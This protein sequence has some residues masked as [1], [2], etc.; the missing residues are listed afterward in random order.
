MWMLP[1]K[2]KMN[3]RVPTLKKK[4]KKS[5]MCIELYGVIKS[6]IKEIASPSEE[7]E[8]PVGTSSYTVKVKLKIPNIL[9]ILL[10]KSEMHLQWSKE[11]MQKL[12]WLPHVKKNRERNRQEELFMWVKDVWTVCG[13]LAENNPRILKS[14]AD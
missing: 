10:C 13:N 6:N 2:L 4:K 14:I 12:L 5:Q 3:L 1:N 9:P 8:E 11:A 7:E